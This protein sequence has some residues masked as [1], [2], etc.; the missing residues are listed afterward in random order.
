[1]CFYCLLL[2]NELVYS[3]RKWEGLPFIFIREVYNQSHICLLLL[4]VR[5]KSSTTG[6][7][8]WDDHTS[9]KQNDVVDKTH[10]HWNW[11]ELSSWSLLSKEPGRHSELLWL[12]LTP[13]NFCEQE[14]IHELNGRNLKTISYVLFVCLWEYWICQLLPSKRLQTI[15][16]PTVPW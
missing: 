16:V 7:Q 15:N 12:G 4:T 13:R 9:I 5:L 3:F 11:G 1:M 2:W 10:P 14:Y 8:C 6:S